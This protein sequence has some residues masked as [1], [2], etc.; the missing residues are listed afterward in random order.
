MSMLQKIDEWSSTHH[1][2]WLTVLRVVL[3]LFLFIKGFV[4]I[5]NGALLEL[6]LT[7][8]SITQKA[9]W[10]STAIPWIHLLGGSMI[11]T[12]LFTRLAVLVQIPILIGAIF[13]VNIKEGFLSGGSDLSF[14]IILLLLLLFFLVEGGGPLSLDNY[15]RNSSKR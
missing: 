3:G 8:S 5:K 2:K 1:P 9:L 12:G 14:S 6:I 13:L 15:F 7:N 4:F 10:L 11:I